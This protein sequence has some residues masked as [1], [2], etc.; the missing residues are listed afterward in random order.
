MAVLSTP[1]EQ[2]ARALKIDLVTAK[3]VEALTDARIR[4]IVLKGPSIA[5]WL[6]R[7]GAPRPYGDSDVLVHPDKLAP[8]GEVLCSLG[9][10]LTLD[11]WLAPHVD[12]HHQVWQRRKDRAVVELHWRLCGIRLAARKA[13][14]PLTEAAET[15]SLAG[16]EVEFLSPAAR[17]LHLALHAAQHAAA[18]EQCLE[19]LRRG[20]RLLDDETWHR[21]DELARRIDAVDAFGGGLRAVP[22]GV[23]RASGLG[24]PRSPRST[25]VEMLN[26]DAPLRSVALERVVAERGWR[27]TPRALLREAFPS[28]SYMRVWAQQA[29]GGRVPL[30][31]AYGRRNVAFLRDSIPAIRDVVRARRRNGR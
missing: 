22:L 1:L 29:Y 25:A 27:G 13:W 15:A 8:A 23:T 21:A 18:K 28:R 19:D 7:D 14:Y 11:D 5:R 26:A 9:F 4:S 30:P 20:L 12:A 3:A 2:T 10:E 17:A 31:L 16:A 6:Y 24:L